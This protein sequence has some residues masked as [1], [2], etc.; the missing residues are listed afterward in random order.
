MDRPDPRIDGKNYFMDKWNNQVDKWENWAQQKGRTIEFIY[1]G[2]H[3][4][5]E[6]LAREDHRGRH[7]F[8]FNIQK[9]SQNWFKTR[10]D[11]AVSNA[12]TRYTPELNVKLPIAQ[13]FDGLGR[14]EA[15]FNRIKVIRGKIKKS[16]SKVDNSKSDD[17]IQVREFQRK[18]HSKIKLNCSKYQ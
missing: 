7:L 16:H 6:R 10:V 2:E 18:N 1:W 12:G 9:F 3:E 11:E 8:W 4:I 15:F 14:T 17:L 13:L 5:C